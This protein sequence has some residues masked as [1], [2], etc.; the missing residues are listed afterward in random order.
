MARHYRLFIERFGGFPI[1]LACGPSETGKSTSLRI[2][3]S[4]TGGHQTSY[5]AKG[6]NAYFLERS[7]LSSLPYGTD[8]P[9][10][11]NY[12]GRRQLDVGELIYS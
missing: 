4:L 3:L 7:A 9:N 5:Y 2:G 11:S 6:T 10:M 12:A 8:D 1:L